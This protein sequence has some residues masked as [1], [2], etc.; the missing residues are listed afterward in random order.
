MVPPPVRLGRLWGS[1]FGCEEWKFSLQH[2][3][4]E[5]WRLSVELAVECASLELMLE[6][7][8]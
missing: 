3:E 1:K 4:D 6:L 7:E 5:V 2:W 8:V